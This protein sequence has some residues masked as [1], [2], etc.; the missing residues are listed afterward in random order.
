MA[1]VID[2]DKNFVSCDTRTECK[3][4]K[5][6]LENKDL[7]A[8]LPAGPKVENNSSFEEYIKGHIKLLETFLS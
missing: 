4:G 8:V 6:T 7:Q 3:I 1:K 2:K 5:R